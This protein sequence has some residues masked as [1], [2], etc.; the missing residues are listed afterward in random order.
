MVDVPPGPKLNQTVD[1]EDWEAWIA[2]PM[3]ELASQRV[4]NAGELLVAAGLREYDLLAPP[5]VNAVLA[6][7]PV[8]WL[9]GAALLAALPDV[10]KR[11]IAAPIQPPQPETNIAGQWLVANAQGSAYSTSGDV[12]WQ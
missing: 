10:P 7:P 9:D 2:R 5:S 12:P 4:H 1:T 8:R 11:W 3:Q 6:A